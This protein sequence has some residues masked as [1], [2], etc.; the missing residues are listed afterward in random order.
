ML[1]A[2]VGIAQHLRVDAQLLGDLLDILAVDHDV[3]IIRLL[4]ELG[5]EILADVVRVEQRIAGGAAVAQHLDRHAGGHIQLYAL[6]L[7]DIADAV[8]ISTFE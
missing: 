1:I 5:E 4:L 2:V 6:I 3:R 7:A 8:R